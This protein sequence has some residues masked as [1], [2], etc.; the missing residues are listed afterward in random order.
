MNGKTDTNREEKKRKKKRKK[1]KKGQ[2][3]RQASQVIK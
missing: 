2:V 3:L 1:K